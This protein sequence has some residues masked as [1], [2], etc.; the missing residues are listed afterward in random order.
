MAE[1]RRPLA[2]LLSAGILTVLAPGCLWLPTYYQPQ[3]FSSTYYRQLQLYAAGQVAPVV[4]PGAAGP[5]WAAES[6]PPAAQNLPS[7]PSSAEGTVRRDADQN[8]A[9]W[10]WLRKPARSPTAVTEG[11]AAE[12]TLEAA[13]VRH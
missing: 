2:I 7:G 12:P 11:T 10:S 4:G 1:R 13:D 9:W 8:S 5:E 3:G 6:T